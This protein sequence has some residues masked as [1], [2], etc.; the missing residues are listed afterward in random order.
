M[1]DN[2]FCTKQTK[3]KSNFEKKY[4][5]R[6][7]GL[8]DKQQNLPALSPLMFQKKQ[9]MGKTNVELDEAR[10]KFEA[11]KTNFQ[12]KK[13]EIDEKQ[14]VL[15]I[16]KENLKTFTDH[17]N[18]E[19]EK[20]RRRE[21]EEKLISKG[22][23]ENL[24]ILTAEEEELIKQNE[25]LKKKIEKLQPCADSY[26][27]VEDMLNRYE[28]LTQTRQEYVEKFQKLHDLFG[29]EGKELIKELNE[30]NDLLID[31]SMQLV[32]RKNQV[33]Q[34]KVQN[35]HQKTTALNDIQKIEME[36]TEV[37]EIKSAI[38]TI[39]KR[40]YEKSITNAQRA[41]VEKEPTIKEMILFIKNMYSDLSG[42][43]SDPNVKY[44][45][46]TP[47]PPSSPKK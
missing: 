21:E 2:T 26:E 17:H 35:Q 34:I 13:K 33:N 45:Q 7:G 6:F 19:I 10:T 31:K 47:P 23:L 44:N 24:K 11:W 5:E 42:I 30:K 1:I 4:I 27:S 40:A 38:R 43:L 29:V 36:K 3:H 9:E 8:D 14:Y 28:T 20:A 12:R 46:Y 32:K 39:F 22:I 15:D 37:A 25:E 18:I 16:Q 41:S